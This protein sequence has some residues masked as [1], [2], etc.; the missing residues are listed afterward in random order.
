[1]KNPWMFIGAMAGAGT[2]AG[3]ALGIE[4][5]HTI[6]E[7]AVLALGGAIGG[8]VLGTLS[9]LMTPKRKP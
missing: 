7:I 9:V 6:S 4:G 5:R 2:I 3:V 1:M 8:F